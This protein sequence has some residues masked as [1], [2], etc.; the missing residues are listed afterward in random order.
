MQ[1]IWPS[2]SPLQFADSVA[3]P[4]PSSRPRSVRSLMESAGSKLTHVKRAHKSL[5]LLVSA[6]G[7]LALPHSLVRP[8]LTFHSSL[9]EPHVFLPGYWGALG[10]CWH[11]S[12]HSRP[13]A[14][15][16]EAA[17]CAAWH[18]FLC[19]RPELA[20]CVIHTSGFGLASLFAPSGG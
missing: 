8:R 16:R 5:Q 3:L 9:G 20:P 15:V 6:P 19:G 12:P 11:L 1:D 10:R 7:Q 4:R 18:A 2:L 17:I 13:V 14:C